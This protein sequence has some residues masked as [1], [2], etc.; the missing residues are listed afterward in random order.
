MQ[1]F[2]DEMR[3]ENTETDRKKLLTPT[4]QGI[5]IYVFFL[6]KSVLQTALTFATDPRSGEGL[7]Y[8]SSL[9]PLLLHSQMLKTFWYCSI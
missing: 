5:F 9:V 7:V 2:N 8:L 4:A 1:I 3:N 6:Y